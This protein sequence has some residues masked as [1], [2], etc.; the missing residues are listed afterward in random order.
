VRT[1]TSRHTPQQIRRHVPNRLR[2]RHL[3]SSRS[4]GFKALLFLGTLLAASAF[5]TTPRAQ[6]QP[7]AEQ[8]ATQQLGSETAISYE[9]LPVQGRRQDFLKRFGKEQVPLLEKLNRS[10]RAHLGNRKIIVVPARWDL[11]EL[12]YSPLPLEYAWA[13]Q[14]PK[15]LL[16]DQ[17]SQTFGAYEQ[18][19][20][21]RWG[22][23]STGKENHQTPAGFSHLNWKTTGRNSTDNPEWYLKWYFNFDNKSGRS[24]HEYAMPG[25]A[26]SNACI[27]LLGR[28]AEW[29]YHWGEQWRLGPRAWTVLAYGT[30][31]L[32]LGHYDFEAPAP[33]WLA[34]EWL[35]RGV[36]LPPV[37]E[38]QSQPVAGRAKPVR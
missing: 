13:E 8:P 30:P 20:L 21:V 34:P 12:A 27:R 32:I 38:L 31:L 2:N 22:P 28:D 29:I 14:Y 25:R 23:V 4:T 37:P 11:D 24:F 10:D 7:A 36:E 3:N 9:L 19:R 35:A 15:L 18:G 6:P 5:G 1:D 16:V 33:P 17:P 26:A